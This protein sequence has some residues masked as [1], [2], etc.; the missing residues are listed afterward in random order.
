LHGHLLCLGLL[1]LSL[2]SLPDQIN[3]VLRLVLREIG[4][5]LADLGRSVAGSPA[6]P[7]GQDGHAEAAEQRVSA[8]LR[9]HGVK[10]GHPRIR[11]LGQIRHL[12][13]SPVH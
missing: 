6:R 11:G 8:A 13:L 3:V 5:Q 9:W 2:R 4:E 12:R 7:L 10:L 1:H